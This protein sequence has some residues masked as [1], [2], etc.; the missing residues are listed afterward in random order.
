MRPSEAAAH[1]N[2]HFISLTTFFDHSI[3][4]TKVW[5]EVVW[6]VFLCFSVRL[7]E[8]SGPGKSHKL[9]QIRV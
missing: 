9:G 1:E 5:I 2:S 7:E 6:Q 8:D 3:M 4:K